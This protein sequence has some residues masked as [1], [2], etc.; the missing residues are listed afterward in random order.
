MKKIW[1]REKE[2]TEYIDRLEDCLRTHGVSCPVEG[3]DS[4]YMKC[5]LCIC[6][7]IWFIIL[8]EHRVVDWVPLIIMRLS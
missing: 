8:Y 3:I 2:R 6:N 5:S 7:K 4:N 1:F